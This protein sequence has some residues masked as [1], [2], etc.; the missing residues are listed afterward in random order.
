MP[1]DLEQEELFAL[2]NHP[3][4]RRFEAH[5][6]ERIIDI[7]RKLESCT[8]EDLPQLQGGVKEIRNLLAH[9][10]GV[11]KSRGATE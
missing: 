3:G 9:M 4:Y 7:H 1:S 11:Y 8:A 6:N 10:E 2:M 5:M